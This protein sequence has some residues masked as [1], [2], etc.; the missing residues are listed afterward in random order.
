MK[1][2][3]PIGVALYAVLFG[4][5]MAARYEASGWVVR[6][7]LAAAAGVAL[8]LLLRA[9][10]SRAPRGSRTNHPHVVRTLT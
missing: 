9:S 1:F 10:R 7:L 8:A 6:I 2:H 4:C 5:I 3:N